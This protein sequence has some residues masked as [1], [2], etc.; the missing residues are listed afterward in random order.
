[1]KLPNQEIFSRI[2]NIYVVIVTHGNRF[3]FL[4]RTIQACLS[5]EV[6][7]IIVVDNKST[8]ESQKQLKLYADAHIGIIKIISLNRNTGSAGGFKTGIEKAINCKD[9]EYVLLLD[10]DNV[11][12]ENAI[13]VI[14]NRFN[15][16]ALIYNK[17]TFLISCYRKCLNQLQHRKVKNGVFL[18]FYIRNLPLKIFRILNYK[19]GRNKTDKFFN[20]EEIQTAPW[21]GLFFHKSLIKKYGLPRQDFVLYAGDTEFT[22]RITENNGKIFLIPRAK[23]TDIDIPM[24][25]EKLSFNLLS[26]FNVT[27]SKIYYCLRNTTFFETHCKKDKTLTRKIN[28]IIYIFILKIFS[29]IYGNKKRFNTIMQAINDG[30]NGKLGHNPEFPL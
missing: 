12:S 29:L 23:I 15:N 5:N 26:Y 6:K 4:Q 13:R 2:K 10:D 20:E 14:L 9:C 21:G 28:K 18:G 11:L 24:G 1:M 22:Y 30:E 25:G 16:L 7:A 17:D 3:N 19:K 27:E 8:A